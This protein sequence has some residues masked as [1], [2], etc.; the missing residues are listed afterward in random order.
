MTPAQQMEM[1]R[2]TANMRS[3][4]DY[5]GKHHPHEVEIGG[6]SWMR[7]VRLMERRGFVTLIGP[8][9]DR[10]FHKIKLTAAGLEALAGR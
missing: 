7:T 3:L 5:A 2:F 1:R 10:G 8:A 4:L 6:R 9:R